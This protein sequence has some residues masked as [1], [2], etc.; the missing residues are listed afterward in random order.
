MANVC[1][2]R[3]TAARW[4]SG[5]AYE[6]SISRSGNQLAYQLWKQSDTIWR[7]DLSDER[8]ALAP[9]W[10]LLSGRGFVSRPSYSPDGKRVVF[11]SNRMGYSDIWVCDSDGSNCS[12]LTA[13][14]AKSGTARWSPN[15][16]SV[17][18]ESIAQDYYQ[19][20]VVE[21]PDG[22]PHMLTSFPGV[23]NGA[24][25][26]SR[27]GKWIY[28]YSSHDPVSSQLWKMPSQGGPPV[29]ATTNGGVYGI[30]SMDRRFLYYAKFAEPGIW[31]K[32]LD[33]GQE[34]RLSINNGWWSAWDVAR[35]GIYF[36]NLD[37]PPNGR[38]EFFDFAHGHS[39]PIFALDKP[40]PLGSGLALSPDGK[41]L[42]FGQSELTE[43]DVMVMKNFR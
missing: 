32:S 25:N 33:G 28:F 41:S 17:S 18:F 23:N 20:G 39:T 11:Q 3:D 16:H 5:D 19:V 31:K 36:M 21:V 30:E 34:S 4:R 35:G 37:F 1:L 12:Q 7:L 42:L 2:R 22:I 14:H 10:R 38:I 43:S 6:P 15:R 8:N 26:W 27:D 29:R 24:P 40:Y 13:L 9:P